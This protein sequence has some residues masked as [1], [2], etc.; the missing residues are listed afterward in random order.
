MKILNDDKHPDIMVCKKH[1]AFL[2][3]LTILVK[4]GMRVEVN[5]RDSGKILLG[6]VVKEHRN[7]LYDIKF[8]TGTALASYVPRSRLTVMTSSTTNPPSSS[9]RGDSNY[10]RDSDKQ[11]LKYLQ[12]EEEDEDEEQDQEIYQ[13]SPNSVIKRDRVSEDFHKAGTKIVR[14][15]APTGTKPSGSAE[16]RPPAA[17]L[18]TPAMS[19]DSFS[20]VSAEV[21]HASSSSNTSMSSNSGSAL[22]QIL[23]QSRVKVDS[24]PKT[25][26]SPG[27]TKLK[28]RTSSQEETTSMSKNKSVTHH[29]S[30]RHSSSKDMSVSS[31]GESVEDNSPNVNINH[32]SSSDLNK[33]RYS[34]SVGT[35]GFRR[36]N[37]SFYKELST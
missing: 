3:Q 30:F 8:D 29:N 7:N 6:E 27:Y 33:T 23:E 10:S 2:K 28:H 16:K 35:A 37:K 4:V 31:T 20:L 13:P 9:S 14:R 34:E 1:L 19:Q 26:I 17:R 12:I 11:N 36:S 24:K 15:S 5:D 22:D 25:E 32:N 18:Q 21:S